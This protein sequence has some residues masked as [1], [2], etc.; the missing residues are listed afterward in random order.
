MSGAKKWFSKRTFGKVDDLIHSIEDLALGAKKDDET[1]ASAQPAAPPPLT[2]SVSAPL[3]PPPQLPARPPPTSAPQTHAFIGGFNPGYISPDTQPSLSFPVPSIPSPPRRTS[4]TMQHALSAP[5]PTYPGPAPSRPA[6]SLFASPDPRPASA[7]AAPIAP[8]PN[9]SLSVPVRRASSDPSSPSSSS[10]SALQCSGVTKANKRCTR[11]VKS[12]PPLLVSH[13]SLG[14]Q[15]ERYCFQHRQEVMQPSGFYSRRTQGVFVE[16]K[17]LN[18]FH[19]RSCDGV[20]I[21]DVQT[22]Y[23]IICTRRRRLH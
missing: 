13:P 17:G 10:G 19:L 5:Q 11:I 15:L 6:L 9:T 21:E 3:P 22:I 1:K 8:K 2:S 16:F 18:C 12:G 20:L 14:E 4:L 23:L 7:A